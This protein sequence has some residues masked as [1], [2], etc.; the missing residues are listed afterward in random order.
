MHPDQ[1]KFTGSDESYTYPNLITPLI[2]L[3][4]DFKKRLGLKNI[5]IWCPFD[6]KQGLVFNG[7]KLFRSN[8]VDIF[9][10]QGYNVIASHIA[11]GQDFLKWQPQEDWDIIISNPPFKNKRKFFERAISFNKPFVLISGV[12][13]LNDAAPNKIFVD[14]KL[15]LLIPQRRAKFFNQNGLIGKQPSFKACYFCYGFLPAGQQIKFIN[16]DKEA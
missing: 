5:T 15:Q 10:K 9:E 12:S 13:W 11:T 3:I 4:E 7:I 8:Y 2:P 16:I 1:Y 14:E 6:L